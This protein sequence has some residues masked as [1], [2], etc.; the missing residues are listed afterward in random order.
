MS[1]IHNELTFRF[2]RM[3]WVGFSSVFNLFP[4]FSIRI[5]PINKFHFSLSAYLPRA[6]SHWLLFPSN[7]T[8]IM[9]LRPF[10]V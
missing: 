10:F 1:Q 4:Q 2:A 6:G 7:N 5:V 3:G 9:V 8:F